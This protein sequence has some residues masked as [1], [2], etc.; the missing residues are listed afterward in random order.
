MIIGLDGPI[1][2]LKQEE[3]RTF[4]EEGLKFCDEQANPAEPVKE[5]EC[6]DY[7]VVKSRKE[8]GSI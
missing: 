8:W 4:S 3:A 2:A 6:N 1:P 7:R 5:W